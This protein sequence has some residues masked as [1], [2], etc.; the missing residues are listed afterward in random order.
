MGKFPEDGDIASRVKGY[1]KFLSKELDIEIGKTFSE[2]DSRKKNSS[3]R[4]SSNWQ[5]DNGCYA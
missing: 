3:Y 5:P 2:L 1:E 4:G